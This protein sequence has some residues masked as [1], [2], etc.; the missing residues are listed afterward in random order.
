MKPSIRNSPIHNSVFQ[1][2][3]KYFWIVPI[4]LKNLHPFLSFKKRVYQDLWSPP[5][6][7][8]KCIKHLH[9]ENILKSFEGIEGTLAF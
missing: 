3:H 1:T 4:P 2:M 9:S 5:R 6:H 8:K 7:L